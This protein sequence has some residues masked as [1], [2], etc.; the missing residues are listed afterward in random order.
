M[1]NASNRV[2]TCRKCHADANDNF[3]Q[4]D[5]HADRHD[6]ARSASLCYTGK[7]MD[8]L[9]MTVF[10]FFGIHTA[11]WLARGL[12]E[13]GHVKW[14]LG[15]SGLLL[16]F[17]TLM[18]GWLFN[19]HMRPETFPMDPVIFTGRLTEHELRDERPDEYDQRAANGGLAAIEVGPSPSWIVP[20]ARIFAAAV[21]SA[22]F[23]VILIILTLVQGRG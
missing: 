2:T 9:L 8:G 17:P 1:V 12:R 3:A 10:G 4:Y 15:F 6:T 7:F 13:R 19:T 23:V 21:V 11:L 20:S 22:G 14:F 18:P 5:P 16:W